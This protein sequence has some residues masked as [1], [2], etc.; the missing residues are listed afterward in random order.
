MSNAEISEI[1]ELLSRLMDIYGENSFKSKS[2]STAAFRIEKYEKEVDTMDDTEI[3]SIPG[4]GDAIAKKIIEIKTT[5]Q[6]SLLNEYLEK[7]PQGIIELLGIKGIGPKKVQQLWA[8]LGIQSVED[9]EAAA[10]ANKLVALKGFTERTQEEILQKISFRKSSEDFFLWAHTEPYALQLLAELQQHFP[11]DLTEVTGLFRRQ[12]PT[13]D[14]IEFVTTIMVADLQAFFSKMEDLQMQETEHGLVI[15]IPELPKLK[16][17]T[18]AKENYYASL[19]KTSCSKDFLTAFEKSS[20]IK[21]D[22]ASEAEIFD[23]TQMQFVP[24]ALREDARVLGLAK[25]NELPLLIATGDIKGLIHCHSKWSDGKFTIEEMAKAAIERGLEYMVLSDHSKSAFYAKGLSPERIIAQHKEIDALNEQLAP[26]RIF[27]SIE[28]DIL[29]NGSLDYDDTILKSFDIVIASVHSILNMT[30]A[31]AMQ[32]LLQAIQNPY[33]NILGHPTGRLLLRREGYPVDHKALIQA[34]ID[35]N[36]VIEINASPRRLDLDWTWVQYALEQGAMLS[37]NPDA[38]S[39]T[40][41]DDIRYGVLAA[42]KGG[43]TKERNLSSMSLA[44]FEKYIESKNSK[45]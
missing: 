28:S 22:A 25:R 16:F 15:T 12:M 3:R 10:K 17:Y 37:I 19:F 26:F 7:T 20:S 33:T 42:Q 9:L 1:F 34:C 6:L 45:I 36:V 39:I 38:H 32:R 8:Q 43:L 5:G 2:Y 14:I 35:H 44:E 31:K 23:A 30:E 40:G 4:I 18:A 21:E 13:L 27:K 41:M 24:P 29:P 11:G